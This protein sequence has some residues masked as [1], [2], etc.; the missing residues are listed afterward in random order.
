MIGVGPDR[1]RE[2]AGILGELRRAQPAHIL[3]P[4]D[5]AAMP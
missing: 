2:R 1:V 5:R 4:L 3:D